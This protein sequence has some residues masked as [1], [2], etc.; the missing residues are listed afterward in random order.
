MRE[1]PVLCD[2]END[3]QGIAW[4]RNGENILID[5]TFGEKSNF[6]SLNWTVFPSGWIRL[7]VAYRPQEYFSDYMGI[8]FSFPEEAIQKVRWMGNGP[9]RVWKNRMRGNRL[10]VWENQYNNTITGIGD[11]VYPEF[12]GY[13]SG[14]YWTR[15][16]TNKKSFTV[17]MA[18]ED[19]FLRLLT[20][21]SPD[22]PYNTSPPFPRGDIS[23]LQAIPPIGTKSQTPENL[24][25][26]GR[27]NMYFDYW[28][29][30]AK[31]MTL[32]FDFRS[33]PK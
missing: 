29:E 11:L 7:D 16:Y 1:G 2:G 15:F 22:K 30:R 23:F 8:N 3:L 13:F 19:V 9:Y 33:K 17:V 26:S 20:P 25:P 5:Y 14:I 27:K 24:G 6:K 12:K 32:Y 4:K 18:S 10:G 31:E 28:K 21:D